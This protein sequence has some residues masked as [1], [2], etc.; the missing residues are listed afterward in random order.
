MPNSKLTAKTELR[1]VEI[2]VY[3]TVLEFLNNL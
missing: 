3:K 1:F 2:F